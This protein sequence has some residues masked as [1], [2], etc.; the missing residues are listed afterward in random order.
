VPVLLQDLELG[1]GGLRESERGQ[2]EVSR[3]ANQLAPRRPP[4]LPNFS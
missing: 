1:L 4:V 3:S 2:E